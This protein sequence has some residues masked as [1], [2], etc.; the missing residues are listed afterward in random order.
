MGWC[1]TIRASD[2]LPDP[3]AVQPASSTVCE[4]LGLCGNNMEVLG[5]DALLVLRGRDWLEERK[6]QS[7]IPEGVVSCP[8]N[9]RMHVKWQSEEAHVSLV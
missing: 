7:L 8:L 3:K 4:G 6:Y 5:E 9:Q 2:L 1:G